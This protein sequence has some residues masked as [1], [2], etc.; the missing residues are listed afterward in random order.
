MFYVAR[1]YE[2]SWNRSRLQLMDLFPVRVHG[3]A[4]SGTGT[5]DLPE[6]PVI[7]Q[8]P[9]EERGRIYSGLNKECSISR[10]KE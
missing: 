7:R 6:D 8:A 5:L 1:M 9:E 2:K 4:Q 10:L 3:K